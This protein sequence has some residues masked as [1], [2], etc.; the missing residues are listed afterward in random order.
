MF[1]NERFMPLRGWSSACLLPTDRARYTG[2]RGSNSDA[3]PQ[4]GLE[5]GA[6]PSPKS[7]SIVLCKNS[8][9]LTAH[10]C[11]THATPYGKLHVLDACSGHRAN[12]T[13]PHCPLVEC[14][15]YCKS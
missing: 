8:L 5:P 12:D 1:E 9:S 11:D 10:V 7:S 15:K 2:P 4:I 14:F 3:F 6:L 13:V